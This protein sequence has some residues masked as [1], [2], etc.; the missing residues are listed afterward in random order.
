ML[1]NLDKRVELFI[2]VEDTPSKRRLVSILKTHFRDT[3]KSRRLLPDGSYER[4][5]AVGRRRLL[6][7]QEALY[8]EACERVREARQ[9]KPTSFEPHRPARIQP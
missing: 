6:R 1:R 3:V 9:E 8:Q 7:S 5:R 2:P 4:I